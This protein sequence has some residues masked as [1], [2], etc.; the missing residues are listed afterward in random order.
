MNIRRYLMMRCTTDWQTECQ[1][2]AVP[3]YSGQTLTLWHCTAVC[4][5][6]HDYAAAVGPAYAHVHACNPR[7]SSPANVTRSMYASMHATLTA[8]SRQ[9]CTDTLL[10][11]W[12][13]LWSQTNIHEA[14]AFTSLHACLIRGAPWGATV[15]PC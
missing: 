1:V 6:K 14:C 10:A 2:I 11:H 4:T 5:V 15:E 9:I 8:W 3:Q 13:E 12:R 7:M